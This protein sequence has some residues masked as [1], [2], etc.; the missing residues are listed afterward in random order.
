MCGRTACTLCAEDVRKA[1]CYRSEAGG[2][3]RLPDWR[4]ADDPRLSYKPSHNVAPTDATPV[5]VSGRHFPGAGERVLQTMLWGMIPPWHKGD[6]KSHGLSTNNC[7]LEGARGS[8]LYGRAL[9]RG[10]RCC[11]VLDGFY[12]WQAGTKQPYFVYCAAQP[13]GFKE[14]GKRARS[15]ESAV[16]CAGA[17]R[18]PQHVGLPL[19]AG[20]GL[21]RAPTAP[22]R[23]AVRRVDLTPGDGRAQLLAYHDGG[24]QVAGLAPPQD[25]RGSQLG[26]AS[27]RVAG[28]RG[29]EGG[30]RAGAAGSPRAAGVAPGVV[31]RQQRAAQGRGLQQ[32]RGPGTEEREG[33]SEQQADEVVAP[34]G[35]QEARRSSGHSAGAD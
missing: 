33:V 5:L 29:R 19:V 32:A 15:V 25:A 3:Y 28:L 10:Q 12:E 4:E 11:V 35:R 7:R 27:G 21:V 16:R 20:G 2:V 22:P 34:V 9:G 6:P 18:R 24:G 31:P 26:A 13:D 14:E 23:S 1:C 17:D 30:R 8:K